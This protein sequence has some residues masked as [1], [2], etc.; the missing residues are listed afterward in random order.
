MTTN[1]PRKINARIVGKAL[2]V[3]GF[4][5]V[6]VWVTEGITVQN[7]PRDIAVRVTVRGSDHVALA[8]VCA[9]I[10]RA[11]GFHVT[12][13]ATSDDSHTALTVTLG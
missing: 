7:M 4:E 12:T 10:L 6:P 13:L 3:N 8:G 9:A 1:E 5:P 11:E 2:Y